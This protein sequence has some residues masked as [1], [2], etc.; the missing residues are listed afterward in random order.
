MTS[1]IIFAALVIVAW[2]WACIQV[3]EACRGFA[4]GSRTVRRA[5]VDIIVNITIAGALAYGK[6]PWWPE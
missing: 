3:Y 4:E 6:W 1:D 5:A 2:I